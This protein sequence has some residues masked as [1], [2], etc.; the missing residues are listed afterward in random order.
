MRDRHRSDRADRACLGR[1]ARGDADALDDLYRRHSTTTWRHA[2]WVTGSPSDAEDVLQNVF[3]LLASGGVDLLGVRNFRAY[4]GSMVH[5]EALRLARRRDPGA[6]AEGVDPDTLL[7]AGPSVELAAERSL[8][9]RQVARLPP[10]QREV[11]VLR[12]YGGFTFRE[13]G[14][15]VGVSTFTAASRFRLALGRLRRNLGGDR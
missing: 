3:V 5:H 8:L 6:V 12:I 4:L 15:A 11:L 14:R 7:S 13:I 2:L 1:L 10:D 9:V